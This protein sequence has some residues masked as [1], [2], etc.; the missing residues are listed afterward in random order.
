MNRREVLKYGAYGL[1][2]QAV[3]PLAEAAAG[4]EIV[5]CAVY[6]SIGIA[7]VGNSPGGFFIGPEVPGNHPLPPGGFKDPQGRILRQAARFRIFGFD[8]AG[9]VVA[10]LTAAAA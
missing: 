10:E 7:R 2:A 5:R 8:A 6:P 1:A 3:G 9:N 4:P